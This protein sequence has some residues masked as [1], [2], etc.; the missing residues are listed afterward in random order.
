MPLEWVAAA[1]GCASVGAL[2]M[3]RYT[4]ARV[5]AAAAVAIVVVGALVARYPVIAPPDLT[6]AEAAAPASTLPVTLGILLAGLAVTVP[7]LV[8]LLRTFHPAR[9]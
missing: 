9:S 5:A 2:Y 3:R 6:V 8:V 7:S 4:A 1:A